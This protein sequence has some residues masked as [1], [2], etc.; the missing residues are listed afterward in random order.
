MNNQIHPDAEIVRIVLD[1]LKTHK[2]AALYKIFLPVE[3]LR[4]LKK[5]GVITH[6][7]MRVG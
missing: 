4:I 6:P 5:L 3:V 1:N 7:N 2:P